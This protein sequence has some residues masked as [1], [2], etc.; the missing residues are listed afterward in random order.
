M[1]ARLAAEQEPTLHASLA[2]IAE[3][4][5]FREGLEREIRRTSVSLLGSLTDMEALRDRLV[6]IDAEGASA[7]PEVAAG[8]LGSHYIIAAMVAV[9]RRRLTPE[10]CWSWSPGTPNADSH[11]RI[12]SVILLLDMVHVGRPS[13][14]KV[15]NN[16]GQT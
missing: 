9:A 3:V 8:G 10:Y 4:V 13:R 16:L 6:R 2:N 5:G 12:S 11:C 1:R 7:V 15:G 14:G